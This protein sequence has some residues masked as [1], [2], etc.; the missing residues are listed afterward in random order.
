MFSALV[1]IE[2]ERMRPPRDLVDCARF[3]LPYSIGAAQR[4]A[5]ALA[6]RGDRCRGVPGRFDRLGLR[7]ARWRRGRTFAGSQTTRFLD[8]GK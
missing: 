1:Q 5:R 7:S 2:A 6:P 8:I 3:T 4:C